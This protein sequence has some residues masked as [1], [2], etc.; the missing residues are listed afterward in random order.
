MISAAILEI[1]KASNETE[2][3]IVPRLAIATTTVA[4]CVAAGSAPAAAQSGHC[5]DLYNRVMAL[6]QTGPQS[7][8]YNR[9]ASY[10]SPR[11][12]AAGPQ[13]A[14]AIPDH[15]TGLSPFRPRPL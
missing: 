5:V 2:C 1:E 9:M 4:L 6:Y 7:Y 13:P 8:E 3:E 12:L 11:C 15:I 10:Y 14:R